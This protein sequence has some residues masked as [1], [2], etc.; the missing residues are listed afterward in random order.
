MG[1]NRSVQRF[2]EREH[3]TQDEFCKR[4]GCSRDDILNEINPQLAK[5][6]HG[7]FGISVGK[8]CSVAAK[9]TP[10]QIAWAKK[11]PI[12]ALQ[13]RGLIA[14]VDDEKDADEQ[15][16]NRVLRFMAVSGED[17]FKS[18]YGATLGTV[19]PQAYA[20]W[21]RIGEL[22]VKRGVTEFALDKDLLF[23]NLNF[24]RR[25]TIFQN[26]SLREMAK[27]VL[28]NSGIVLLEMEPFVTVPAPV[29]ASFWVGTQPVIQIPTTPM[30]DAKFLEAIFHAVGHIVKHPLRTICLQVPSAAIAPNAKQLENDCALNVA[31]MN[32]REREAENFA[33]NLLLPEAQECELI[34]CGHFAEKKCI[35][36]FAGVFR[37]RP[38]IL[39]E[40][41]QQQNKI[42]R[43]TALNEFKMVV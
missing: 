25:N 42:S 19:N 39:V 35:R 22:S 26:Q 37:V 4:L 24:L 9:W 1:M 18:Y 33:E 34:C 16:V 32:K 15:L 41:L 38:G 28:D 30:T 43:R 11:F 7:A 40:R 12:R 14:A 36:H 29:C 31:L 23:N 3:F 5:A 17:C 21:I 8:E 27:E 10:S 2:L 6:M 20:A 13:R